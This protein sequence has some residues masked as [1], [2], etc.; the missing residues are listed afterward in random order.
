MGNTCMSSQAAPKRRKFVPQKYNVEYDKELE[1]FPL[2]DGKTRM[3]YCP[4]RCGICLYGILKQD[5]RCAPCVSHVFHSQCLAQWEAHLIGQGEQY[6]CPTCKTID[7][8]QY[9]T[10][11]GTTKAC[12]V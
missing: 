10:E 12:E 7:L 3:D 9:I 5:A 4:F 8:N 2:A 1:E 11:D 6:R